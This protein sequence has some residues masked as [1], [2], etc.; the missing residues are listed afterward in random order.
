MAKI[1]EVDIT[2]L[3][4]Q[5]G[6]V[7]ATPAATQWKAYFK[8]TGLF[9]VDDAGAETGPLVAAAGSGQVPWALMPYFGGAR[10]AT[11]ISVGANNR[12]IYV[13]LEPLQAAATITGIRLRV[14]ASS[15]NICVGLYDSGGSRVATSGAVACPGASAVADVAFT[16][17]Y[18]AAAGRY[19]AAI[20]ADNTTATFAVGSD[21]T[22]I[23]PA[24]CRFEET[25]HPLPATAT[26]NASPTG[27][28]MILMA[29]ISGGHP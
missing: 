17:S 23:S 29:R 21:S 14:E 18:S 28:Q 15:G 2:S 13:P 27:R 26:F 19:Y 6:S 16:V 5:E 1:N 8:T 4:F 10:N 24:T 22:N 25:A 7:P 12:A 20:S 9:V 11:A 3:I